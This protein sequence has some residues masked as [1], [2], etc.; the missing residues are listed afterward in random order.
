MVKAWHI[1]A[2][3]A[4]RWKNNMDV[5]RYLLAEN[6]PAIVKEK[7][8]KPVETQSIAKQIG[9]FAG[10]F[11]AGSERFGVGKALSKFDV[12]TSAKALPKIVGKMGKFGKGKIGSK[13][14][15]GAAWTA[16]RGLGS[17]GLAGAKVF[18]SGALLGAGLA[19]A[20]EKIYNKFKKGKKPPSQ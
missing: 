14:A 11:A 18:G 8:P 1:F 19:G 12:N 15:K 5:M 4:D 20:G 9:G 7:K 10:G 2:I 13:I 17:Y 16:G 3:N 6:V